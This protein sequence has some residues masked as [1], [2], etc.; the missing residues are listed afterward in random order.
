[1]ALTWTQRG[2]ADCGEKIRTP[3]A[4]F[5]GQLCA[6]SGLA[7]GVP[8]GALRAQRDSAHL[9]ANS[10][11]SGSVCPHTSF[12]MICAATMLKVMPL[13]PYPSTA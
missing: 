13:P 2:R 10:S 5:L 1:M 12:W 7:I 3:I 8:Y 9:K 11:P 4:V 6:W